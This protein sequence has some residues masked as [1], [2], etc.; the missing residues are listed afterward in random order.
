MLNSIPFI[1]SR[2][3]LQR[4]LVFGILIVT[5]LLAFELFNYSTTDF[6]LSDLLGDLEHGPQRPRGSSPQTWSPSGSSATG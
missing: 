3:K 4:G 1:S 6:A 5:A 2:V